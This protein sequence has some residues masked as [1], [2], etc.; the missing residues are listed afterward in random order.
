MSLGLV[1]A[2]ATCKIIIKHLLKDLSFSRSYLDDVII[3][4]NLRTVYPVHLRIVM[5]VLHRSES[6][7]RANK[8]NFYDDSVGILGHIV[9]TRA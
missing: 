4:L 1:N 9:Y 3:H 6:K 2:L 5:E 7:L 8:C